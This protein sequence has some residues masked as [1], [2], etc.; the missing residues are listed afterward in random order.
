MIKILKFIYTLWFI[1]LS[2]YIFPLYF[3]YKQIRIFIVNVKKEKKLSFFILLKKYM[4]SLEEG[5]IE[6]LDDFKKLYN[7][8]LMYSKSKINLDSFQSNIKSTNQNYFLLPEINNAN[9]KN[10]NS[11]S[12][13][14]D[15]LKSSIGSIYNDL[16]RKNVISLNDVNNFKELVKSVN[17]FV[18]SLYTNKIKKIETKFFNQ[19][20]NI[21][22]TKEKISAKDISHFAHKTSSLKYIQPNRNELLVESQFRIYK[23]SLESGVIPVANVSIFLK[24][25]EHGYLET[26]VTV[27]QQKT[28][29]KTHRLYGGKKQGNFFFG[30]S[31]PITTTKEVIKKIGSGKIV[32]TNKRIVLVGTKINYSIWYDKLTDIK[33]FKDSIQISYEGRYGGRFYELRDNLVKKQILFIIQII[34]NNR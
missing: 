20:K 11:A 23:Q 32:L 5:F 28:Q 13:K 4:S 3:I 24:K 22:N 2:I 33:N 17:F 27:Y 6:S 12:Y 10:K 29:T 34:L 7:V 1:Y 21:L 14:S 25:K 19:E 26:S 31:T 18:R 15:S 16:M 9:R 30:G 8:I